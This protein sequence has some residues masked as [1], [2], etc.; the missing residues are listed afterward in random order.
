MSYHF[1]DALKI[2]PMVL[3]I[4]HTNLI[5]KNNFDDQNAKII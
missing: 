1:I 3:A 5:I 2:V 4:T